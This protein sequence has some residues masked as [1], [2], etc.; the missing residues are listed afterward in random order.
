MIKLDYL[1]PILSNI[2]N[3]KILIKGRAVGRTFGIISI[4]ANALPL[5][6]WNYSHNTIC[7]NP[8]KIQK[9]KDRKLRKACYQAF[10]L[11]KKS[12][13]PKKKLKIKIYIDELAKILNK[14]AQAFSD[15]IADS[16]SFFA[17]CIKEK[18]NFADDYQC[19]WDLGAG[20]ESKS[21]I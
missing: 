13:K 11:Y 8:Q 18:S 17:H 16:F 20:C 3:Q 19:S 5:L 4:C 9:V 6:E 7:F 15:H 12:F 2:S 21:I 14:S 1:S 10:A